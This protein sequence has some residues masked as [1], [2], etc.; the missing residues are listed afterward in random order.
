[1]WRGGGGGGLLLLRRAWPCARACG[2]VGVMFVFLWRG[3]R[4]SWCAY[5]RVVTGWARGAGRVL[6]VGLD[7]AAARANLLLFALP[8]VGPRANDQRAGRLRARPPHSTRV[9]NSFVPF[10]PNH[11]RSL[12]L[13][14]FCLSSCISQ[15]FSSSSFLFVLYLSHLSFAPELFFLLLLISLLYPR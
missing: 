15:Y 4:A 13:S 9:R 5:L 1:V 7:G 10:L 11:S 14:R 8:P 12:C 2:G 3:L 6:V